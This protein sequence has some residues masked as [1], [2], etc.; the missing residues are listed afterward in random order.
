MGDMG[1]CAGA[2]RAWC[3]YRGLQHR[4]K[5]SHEHWDLEHVADVWVINVVKYR[6]EEGEGSGC[7]QT[8]HIGWD[9]GWLMKCGVP[10]L[11]PRAGG[12]S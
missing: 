10:H 7:W 11:H 12:R 2:I 9:W 8:P 3:S 4:A 6:F 1:P 5:A